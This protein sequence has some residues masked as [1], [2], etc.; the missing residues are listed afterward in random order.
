MRMRGLSKSAIM[1]ISRRM[2]FAEFDGFLYHSTRKDL[3]DTIMNTGVLVPSEERENAFVSFS[4]HPFSSAAFSGT[5]IHGPISS[6]NRVC[7]KINVPEGVEKVEYTIE[8]FLSNLD[9]AEYIE[10]EGFLEDF[11]QQYSVEEVFENFVFQDAS[12]DLYI[13]S[14]IKAASPLVYGFRGFMERANEEEWISSI[15]GA[16]VS[17]DVVDVLYT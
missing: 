14:D 11:I 6:D 3:L 4:E 9:K 13:N 8:W 7:L 2:R 15:E 16:P 1:R 12:G 5:G 10:D 17:I